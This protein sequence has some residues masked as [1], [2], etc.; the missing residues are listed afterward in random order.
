MPPVPE[1]VARDNAS[2]PVGAHQTSRV[3]AQASSA[4]KAARKAHQGDKSVLE[5]I[6]DDSDRVPPT[7]TSSGASDDPSGVDDAY[8]TGVGKPLEAASRNVRRAGRVESSTFALDDG[9][10]AGSL[11]AEAVSCLLELAPA[12]SRGRATAPFALAD[13]GA[14]SLKQVPPKPRALPTSNG[15]SGLASAD[16]GGSGGGEAGD[17]ASKKRPS[18]SK[19]NR[20]AFAPASYGG[21]TKRTHRYDAGLGDPR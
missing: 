9:N 17:G 19:K 1:P 21:P 14:S 12:I 18:G 13:G 20:G 7:V 15:N 8:P 2:R 5:L 4:K 3:R 10:V 6:G 16:G 11:E